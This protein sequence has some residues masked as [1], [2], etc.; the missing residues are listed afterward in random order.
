MQ[1]III[2]PG[3][4]ISGGVWKRYMVMVNKTIGEC[5]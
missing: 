3:E 1:D 4:M 5:E 2:L